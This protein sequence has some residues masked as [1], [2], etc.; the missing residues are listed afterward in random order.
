MNYALTDLPDSG[1]NPVI[2]LDIGLKGEIIGRIHIRLFRDSFPAGVENFVKIAEGKTYQVIKKGAGRFTYTKD[3]R[4]T[5]E[6]CKFF[7]FMHNNY[8]VCGDIYQNNGTSAGTVYEDKPIPSIFGE[9][10]YP[11][12]SKGLVSLVP[13]YDEK[14]GQKYYDSTFMITLDS[15]RPTNV[16]SD[17]DT[18]QIVIGKI[19]SGMEVLDK[20]NQLIKPYAGRRYP[21]FIIEKCDVWRR[22]NGNRRARP[23]TNMDKKKFFKK[24]IP[25]SYEEEGG[26]DELVTEDSYTP[27]LMTE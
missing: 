1:K 5:Y 26:I 12:D 7:N 8:F 25:I 9:Y 10:F 16:M 13:F 27:N 21:D 20:M 6:K 3:T 4:R 23:L 22:A 19:S 14:T 18:D 17:L 24:P 15:S 11:H 2:Y